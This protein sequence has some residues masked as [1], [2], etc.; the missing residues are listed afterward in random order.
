M[1]NFLVPNIDTSGIRS[2]D[3]QAKSAFYTGE[4]GKAMGLSN[5]LAKRKIERLPETEAAAARKAKLEEK[6]LGLELEET[7]LEIYKGLSNIARKAIPSIGQEDYAEFREFVTKDLRLPEAL[8]KPDAEVQ[9]MAEDEYRAYMGSQMLDAEK[10]I[11]DMTVEKWKATKEAEQNRLD[12]ESRERI[13]KM[14]AESREKA[15]AKRGPLVSIDMTTKTKGDLEEK[16]ISAGDTLDMLERVGSLYKPEFLQYQGKGQAWLENKLSKLGLS[17]AEFAR[18]RAK[19]AV[20]VDTY[21]LLFRKFITGVA[22][23]EKEME[24]I[25]K[26]TLNTRYDSPAQHEAKMEYMPM[27]A[28]AALKRAMYLRQ[29]GFKTAEEASLEEKEKAAELYPFAP[30]PDE[31]KTTSKSPDKEAAPNTAEGYLRQKGVIK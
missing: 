29:K 31:L 26:V 23:G 9:S 7:E 1:G 2:A 21:S 14:Q 19:W 18:K 24:M 28:E 30:M 3:I 12:R 15:A 27:L 13:A 10:F 5:V 11:Q 16:I 6:K 8:W 20:E 22:G 25:E 4:M 17:E